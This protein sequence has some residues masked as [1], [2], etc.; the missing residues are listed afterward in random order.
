[1]YRRNKDAEG[2]Q[3]SVYPDPL[4]QP[5]PWFRD[6]FPDYR[7]L[8]PHEVPAG[9]DSGCEFTSVCVNIQVYLPWLASQC[10]KEGVAF[11]RACATHISDASSLGHAGQKA[12]VVVNAT[13][14][15]AGKLGGV[16][17]GN[18][19]PARGQ[20]VLV[21]NAAPHMVA[22]SGTDDERTDVCYVMTRAAGGGT[23]LGGTYHVGN[24]DAIPRED[25]AE[26]IM[27]RAV[28]IVPE[29]VKPGQ[30][31]EGLDVVRHGVGLRPVRHGGVRLEREDVEDEEGRK[32]VVVH[33]YGH[34]GWGYQGSYGCAERVVELVEEVKR[35]K[36]FQSK[37]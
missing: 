26:R 4:F 23:V 10:L 8:P 17:D 22:T 13:G 35:G 7:E 14:L 30:G 25:V 27:R 24:W 20:I 34:G 33:N 36:A 29:L 2:E 5:T 32:I 28:E 15:G 21:R 19:V 18:V 12:D 11:T 31:V 1:M 37:L 9:Y 16:R 6:L 3:C